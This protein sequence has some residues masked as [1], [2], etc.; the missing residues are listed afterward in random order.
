[1]IIRQQNL[2]VDIFSS[3]SSSGYMIINSCF[4][5]CFCIEFTLIYIHNYT[6][7][8]FYQS[9]YHLDSDDYAKMCTVADFRLLNRESH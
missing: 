6:I 7:G 5:K 9:F 2:T 3:N 1:M 4:W 8:I